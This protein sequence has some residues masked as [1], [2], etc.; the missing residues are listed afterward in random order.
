MGK[1]RCD[2]NFAKEPIGAQHCSQLGVQ[3][4]EGD[5]SLVLAVLTEVNRRHPAPP[6]LSLDRVAIRQL[7]TEPFRNLFQFPSG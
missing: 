5:E 4:L 3:H 2:F 1:L 6:Q 7:G